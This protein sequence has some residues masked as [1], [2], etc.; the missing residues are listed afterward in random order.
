MLGNNSDDDYDECPR[1]D[2]SVLLC[3]YLNS[4]F[5]EQVELKRIVFPLFHLKLFLTDAKAMG[6][7]TRIFTVSRGL[8]H[9]LHRK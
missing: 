3:H 4:S 5:F 8:Q 2:S 1:E 6:K 9:C 7:P